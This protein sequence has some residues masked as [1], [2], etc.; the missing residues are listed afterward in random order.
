MVPAGAAVDPVPL[1]ETLSAYNDAFPAVRLVGSLRFP[2]E[3][4]VD[5]GARAER[6]VGV[7]I[8][9][10]SGPGKLAFSV[11]CREAEGCSVYLPD[12]ALFL[13]DDAAVAGR[14]LASLVSGR[15]MEAGPVVGAWRSPLGALVLRLASA[16]H[17]QT[18]E[19]DPEGRLP[20]RVLY[21]KTGG[22]PEVEI[23][24]DDFRMEEGGVFPHAVRVAGERKGE[25]MEFSV[26]KV[27][28]DGGSDPAVFTI[29]PPPG[30]EVREG[31]GGRLW[32]ELG[33][34]LVD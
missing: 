31:G 25:G 34:P 20:R 8:D 33:V 7:R 30:I 17:W 13:R 22:G 23:F 2:E 10:V 9:A 5:F 24:L 29:S 15:V 26:R 11:A 3:G 4:T 6:G 21:G 18:V 27:L 32:R 19:F 14:W 12:S 16:R 1:A 28:P